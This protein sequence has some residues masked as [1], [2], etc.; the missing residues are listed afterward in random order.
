MAKDDWKEWNPGLDN[1]G[2]TLQEIYENLPELPPEDYRFLK[3]LVGKPSVITDNLTLFEQDCL[4]IALGRGLL[5]QDEAFVIGYTM[6]TA[7]TLKDWEAGIFRLV[8]KMCYPGTYKFTD[9]DVKAFKLGVEVGSLSPV[10]KLHEFDFKNHFDKTLGEIR[11]E[12]GIDKA[13]LR[14]VYRKEQSLLPGSQVSGR[15]PV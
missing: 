11:E 15:L 2:K 6:G 4:H 14:E 9:D 7:T 3:E 10:R 5:A 1:D 12:L 8:A 13:A